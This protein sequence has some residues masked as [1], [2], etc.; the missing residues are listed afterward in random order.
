MENKHVETM[1]NDNPPIVVAAAQAAPYF[2]DKEKTVQKA[3][4][5]I[6]LA[7]KN[8]AKLLVF[9]EAFI[10]GY[11]DWVWVVPNGNVG[12]LDELY[13]ELVTNAI[14]IPDQSTQQLCQAAKEAGIYVAIGVHER[15]TESSGASLFN[16]ILYIDDLFIL[17]DGAFDCILPSCFFGHPKLLNDVLNFCIFFDK[18]LDTLIQ[19]FPVLFKFV[20]FDS[21]L[22][23]VSDQ[24]SKRRHNAE[25]GN[26]LEIERT[27]A[28]QADA[29]K[30]SLFSLELENRVK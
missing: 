25:V 18:P 21:K 24:L 19:I 4:D 10:S 5:L 11:P 26:P 3:C 8:D 13:A 27:M 15:N 23:Q 17:I 2:L 1:K 12:M 9:P 7:G 30:P 22:P 16:T 14:S 20:C 28:P 6:A 29:V